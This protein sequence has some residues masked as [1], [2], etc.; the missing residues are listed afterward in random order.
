[1]LAPGA[2]AQH[3]AMPTNLVPPR[4]ASRPWLAALLAA[5]LAAWLAGCASAPPA[6]PGVTPQASAQALVRRSLFDPGLQRFIALQMNAPQPADQAWT[7]QRLSLAALYFHPTLRVDRAGVQLAEADLQM[8]RQWPNPT[9]QL[10]LKYG[11]AAALLAPSPWTVGAAIGLLLESH[12][13]R[14]AQAAQAQAGVRAARLLLRGASWQ[15]RSRV[16]QAYVALWA[17]QQQSRVQQQVLDAALELQ[18]RTAA[19][20]Q[21]GWDS[22]LAAALAQ[23]AAQAAALQR[24]HDLGQ[25]QIAHAALAAALGV[26]DAAL[27]AVRLDF[28]ALAATPPQPDAARLTRLRGIALAHRDD[29]RAAWQQE[30]AAQAALQL[31]RALRDG[32]PP[33]LAPGAERDQGVNRLTLSAS[34]PL[35]L[36]NQHQGQIAAAHARLARARAVLQQVQAQALERIEQAEAALRAAQ[37]EARRAD[38]LRTANLEL[39]QADE[40]ARRQ[41]LIG[42][43]QVLQARLRALATERAA[44]QAHAAQWQALGSLQAALQH[45]LEPQPAQARLAGAPLAPRPRVAPQLSAVAWHVP[46]APTR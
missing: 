42:P 18:G 44:L 31:A 33:M 43:V 46:L 20:A 1:M 7:L 45:A 14:Q 36:L 10:G 17:A 19:R 34:V 26:P 11:S 30:Q 12:A 6:A 41:G 38:S 40:S 28:A 16:Q 23:A 2:R 32:G 13:Q 5:L 37:D 9:L 39:L 3:G 25:E 22:P 27:R 29:V 21:G 8:A 15:V 24:S 35:P 4:I